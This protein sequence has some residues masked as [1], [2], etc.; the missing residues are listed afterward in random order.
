MD[1]ARRDTVSHR[2][3]VLIVDPDPVDR[4][5]MRKYLDIPDLDVAEADGIVGALAEAS[6]V[7]PDVVIAD[8]V[9]A[10]G[11]GFALC[12]TFRENPALS[13]KPIVLMSRWS[14]EADRILGFECGADDFLAKPYFGREL[15]SRV[16]AVLRRSAQLM[17]SAEDRRFTSRE[18]LV[19]DSG[20]RVARVDGAVVV[21]TPREFSLLE[22][23]AA[24]GGRVLTRAD[25]IVQAW[26][27]P[28]GLNERSVDAHIKS[29]RRKL[30]AARE[31]VETV[32]GLGYRFGDQRRGLRAGPPREPLEDPPGPPR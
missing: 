32:R 29:L 17:P 10:D 13:S 9:L 23:L 21:L 7:A 12:K 4:E 28:D 1:S 8:L 5:V 16:R 22:A 18:G 19:V 30:G 26:G 11:S 3:R 2:K 15:V 31:A 6:R 27:S 24:A 25:L 20:R 14:L